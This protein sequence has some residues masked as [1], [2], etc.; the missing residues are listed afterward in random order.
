MP[1]SR[2]HFFGRHYDAE[3]SAGP[4]K[5]LN[6][7]KRYLVAEKKTAA[8]PEDAGKKAGAKPG[9]PTPKV[10]YVWRSRD[11]R[12]GRHAV[13]VDRDAREHSGKK[14]PRPSNT[15]QQTV[16][17]IVRMFVRYPVWDVSYD[18]AFV[19]TIGE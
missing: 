5:F 14:V 19:F 17:G 10:V 13:V 12:K 3:H 18:V 16:G 2:D 11:N 9:G 4:F 6:P 1:E 8:S 7:T 15:W